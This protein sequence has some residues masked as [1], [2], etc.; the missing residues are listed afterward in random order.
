MISR[1]AIATVSLVLAFSACGA[2]S[3][4]PATVKAECSI[5]TDPGFP[6]RGARDKDQHWITRAQETG[7]T[8][9]GWPRPKPEPEVP[10]V[11]EPP[12]A[13]V[14]VEPP[15]PARRG[16]RAWLGS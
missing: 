5:F 13:P 10:T 11:S 3:N 2:H 8:V 6:V 15:A 9:C 4:A 1:R 12:P 14:A 16:W 7:I